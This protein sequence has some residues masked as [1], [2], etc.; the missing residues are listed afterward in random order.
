ML[1]CEKMAIRVIVNILVMMMVI[2]KSSSLH[3]LGLF[4]HPG[5]SHFHFFHPI[6]VGL[7]E[8]G[9][10][11][12]VVSHF[13]DAN[14]PSNYK[15]LVIGGQDNLTNSVDLA[16]CVTIILI[17]FKIIYELFIHFSGLQIVVRIT[18]F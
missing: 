2:S 5:V 3:I 12:T 17:D 18:T 1:F 8:K 7:A 13:P 14:A 16:V 11:V 9:H 15:D 4:P 6:M 10:N